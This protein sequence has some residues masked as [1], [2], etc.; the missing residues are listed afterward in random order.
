MI[1][2]VPACHSEDSQLDIE[3]HDNAWLCM[4]QFQIG[5]FPVVPTKRLISSFWTALLSNK[6][7]EWLM[8][9]FS[10]LGLT[11]TASS[12]KN[13]SVTVLFGHFEKSTAREI[14]LEICFTDERYLSSGPW[15]T[16]NL[17]YPSRTAI[18]T[19]SSSAHVRQASFRSSP[20]AQNLRAV[21]KV[22][23]ALIWTD[24]CFT[25]KT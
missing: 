24:Q 7:V 19:Q 12:R 2:F 4:S 21:T 18:L 11:H 6:S 20:Y 10:L 22:G 16:S 13:V 23:T 14:T 5:F 17:F 25:A 8:I 9:L 3:F 15:F 1:C